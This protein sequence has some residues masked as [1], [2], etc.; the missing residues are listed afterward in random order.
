VIVTEWDQVRAFPY[1]DAR[2]VMK[3]PVLVDGRNILDPGEA[4]AAAFLYE[5]IG[6]PSGL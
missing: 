2:R 5:A 6:R 1:G 4:R 3:S